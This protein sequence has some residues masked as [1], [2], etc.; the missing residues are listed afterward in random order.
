MV[1]IKHRRI[2][3]RVKLPSLKPK[4]A[5]TVDENLIVVLSLNIKCFTVYINPFHINFE[6]LLKFDY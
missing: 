1:I 2:I 5:A 3:P 6:R 4:Q